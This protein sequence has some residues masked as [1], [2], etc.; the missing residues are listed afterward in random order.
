MI[1]A[2]VIYLLV[3]NINILYLL[4]VIAFAI[5]TLRNTLYHAFLWQVKEYRLDRIKAH[6]RTPL[7][8][9]F[10][11]GPVSLVKWL[12]LTI[13]L[14]TI[15]I[16]Y[17]TQNFRLIPLA[18]IINILPYWIIIILE[19]VL[20]IKEA[21]I[22]GW[23]LPKFTLKIIILTCLVLSAEVSPFFY[24]DWGVLFIIPFL[25][26]FL[27][28][29]IGLS[30]LFLNFPAY[31]YKL[32]V[33]KKAKYKLKLL[34]DITVIGI[35]GS[36]GKTSTK[37]YL[38]TVLSEKYKVV[39]TPDFNNTDIG[40]AKFILKE[41]NKKHEIFIVEMGAYKRGEIKTICDMVG[42]DIG[43]IT[44]IE[45]QHLELFGSLDHI[46]DAKFELIDSL[47]KA[48]KAYFNGE[49]EYCRQLFSI[50]KNK[51]II[52]YLYQTAGN[53]KSLKILKNGLKFSLI[54][55]KKIYKFTV[56]VLGK[57]NLE[58]IMPSILIAQRLDLTINQI[59]MG[60]R[61]IVSVEKTMRIVKSNK[62]T[63]VDDSFNAGKKA[64]YAAI[65]YMSI[66][67]GN[68]FIILTPLIELGIDSEDIHRKLGAYAGKICD[69]ILLTNSNYFKAI[70]D[71][72]SEN[73]QNKIQVQIINKSIVNDLKNK[74]FLEDSIILFEGK[75]SA[76]IL[77]QMLTIYQ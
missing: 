22:T 19:A 37:E 60:V 51:G 26:R 15:I 4:I 55:N 34:K 77:D 74:I 54:L 27:G 46:K 35:T 50:A 30:V 13:L 76:K 73:K 49:N 62:V 1:I 3:R 8:R 20:N 42:P 33:I 63:F 58:N 10:L 67:R 38:A 11:L 7:G 65:D 16:L 66:Y 71:G 2:N 21:I 75:E 64:V 47:P 40:I 61:K 17:Y 72:V 6:F 25:D 28:F 12:I 5:R 69:M 57:H 48:G 24:L 18:V 39:K 52:S 43:I 53:I 44:G 56:P 9:K 14:S 36:Y 32:I 31:I 23:R 59:Q 70:I 29:F 41:L 68:K 45:G